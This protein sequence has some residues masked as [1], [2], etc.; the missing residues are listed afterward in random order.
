MSSNFFSFH[1]ESRPFDRILESMEPGKKVL[2]LTFDKYSTFVPY[3]VYLHFP[4]WYQVKKG[5]VV[6]F[7][8]AEFFPN[9]FRYKA[10]ARSGFTG[11][12]LKHDFHPEEFV[13]SEHATDYEYFLLRTVR[14]ESS[15][16]WIFGEGRKQVSLK[17]HSGKWWLFERVASY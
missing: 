1:L 12:V 11:P 3:H 17:A 16:A 2:S 8:F 9:R 4:V 13:W 10:G 15:P 6:D 14:E 5:G 7:S